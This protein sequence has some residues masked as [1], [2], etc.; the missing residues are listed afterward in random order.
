MIQWE[1]TVSKAKQ[2][3]KRNSFAWKW[4][5]FDAGLE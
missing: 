5:T 4:S 3:K 1:Q 2:L